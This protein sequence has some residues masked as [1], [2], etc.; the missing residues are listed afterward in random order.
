MKVWRYQ[1]CEQVEIDAPV[2]QV[3]TVA[4]NPQTVPFYA[5]E[6]ARID[7][8]KRLSDHVVLVRSHLRIGKL[9]FAFLY[10][11]HHRPPTHYSGVQE[12]GRLF[13]GYFNL[14]FQPRGDK[15]IVSHTEGIASRI[16][17]LAELVG[18]V[19][20]RILARGGIG[21]EL[22]RLKELAERK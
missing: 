4:S 3:Y 18:F 14:T 11:H 20:F 21:E 10:R 7:V 22:Q 1:T 9:T 12:G 13:R 16:P 5:P 15:T 6:I 19:Y 2:G 17:G 8:V